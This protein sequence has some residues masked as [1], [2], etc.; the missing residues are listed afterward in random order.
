M[1]SSLRRRP[2]ARPMAKPSAKGLNS[3]NRWSSL[4]NLGEEEGH[5]QDDRLSNLPN[6]LLLNTS[7]RLGTADAARTSILS[8][9]WKPIPAM[10]SKICLTVGSSD[11]DYDRSKLT[12][13][14]VVRANA[15]MLQATRNLLENRTSLY[16]IHLLR[17]QFFLG[18]ESDSIG[19]TVADTISTQK[20]GSVELTLLTKKGGSQCSPDDFL[21]HGKRLKSFVDACPNTFSGL[22]RLSLEN[23]RLGE[24]DFPKIL[25]I[26]KQLEFLRLCNCDMG[27]LSLLEVEHPQLRELEILKSDFERVDLNWLPKLTTLSFAC[28]ISKHDPLSFGYVPLLQ[29]LSISNTALSYHKM[30]KLSELLGKATIRDLHLNFESEKIWVKPEGPRELSQVFDKLRLVSLADI[31]EECDLTWTMFV[32]QGAPSLQELSIKVWDHQCDMVEDE[33]LRKRLKYTEVKKDACARWEAPASGFKHHNLT[34]LRIFG[35]QS[36]DKF[37]DYIAGVIEA[38]VGLEDIYLYEKPAC[39]TCKRNTKDSYPRTNKERI[40]LRNIFNWEMC[41]L[42]RIHFPSS[43]N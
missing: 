22:T 40:A 35:F 39:E 13:D 19:R 8:R 42:A 5:H 31:S 6:D 43:R 38:A 26:S 17:L 28:W 36:E 30:L 9:R 12:C 10:L 20:V 14:H 37:V 33:E 15:N 34:V 29:T 1:S 4:A 23:L 2:A 16:P 11:Y 32:L 41:S 18:D 25:S 3:S 7:S 24:S 27:L 21:T